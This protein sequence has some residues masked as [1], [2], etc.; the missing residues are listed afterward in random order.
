MDWDTFKRER[1]E[2]QYNGKVGEAV[3]YI[4][5]ELDNGWLSPDSQVLERDSCFLEQP[6][7]F[8]SFTVETLLADLRRLNQDED[9][10]LST[11]D[12]FTDPVIRLDVL[13]KKALA[14]IFSA[15]PPETVTL[16]AAKPRANILLLTKDEMLGTQP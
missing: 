3:A 16:S 5:W 11:G 6:R 13:P 15:S 4:E 8:G 7:R 1:I 2:P 12:G 14:K 10:G 9:Y